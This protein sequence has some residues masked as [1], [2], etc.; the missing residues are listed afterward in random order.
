MGALLAGCTP[1][2]PTPSP[3]PEDTLVST[4]PSTPSPQ[5]I[6]DP[7]PRTGAMGTVELNS[8]GTPARYLVVEGD[9]PDAICYRFGLA[10]EQLVLAANGEPLGAV[11]FPGE[12]IR[13]VP[14]DNPDDRL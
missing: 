3:Y 9:Y 12:V 5:G 14:Y 10:S 7:G 2:L 13:F 4:V 8:K 11:I 1:T 6:V